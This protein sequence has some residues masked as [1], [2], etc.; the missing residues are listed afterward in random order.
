MSN[1]KF[2]FTLCREVTE[3]VEITVEAESLEAAHNEALY[4]PP[5]FGWLPCEPQESE[6]YLPDPDDYVEMRAEEKAEE[7]ANRA[8]SSGPS[9]G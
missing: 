5:S 9:L 7:A 4:N 8:S 1:A 2:T 3:F 6:I